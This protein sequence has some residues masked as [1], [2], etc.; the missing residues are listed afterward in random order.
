MTVVLDTSVLV[1][2]LV[3]AHPSHRAA[4]PWLRR[5]AAGE[6]RAVVAAHSV[7]ETYAILSTLPHQPRITPAAS[8][9]LIRANMRRFRIVALGVR[10]YQVVV[11]ILAEANLP[12]GIV[13][14]A[15]IARAAAK[16]GAKRIVTLNTRDF[17][18]LEPLFGVKATAP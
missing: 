13:N 10:D 3:E 11:R 12:G 1:A 7:A 5:V 2:G 18:R 8:L 14:D 16:G 15:L 6:T 17:A 4:F 9:Q